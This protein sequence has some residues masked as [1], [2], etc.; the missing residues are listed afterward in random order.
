MRIRI[1]AQTILGGLLLAGAAQAQT[2]TVMGSTALGPIVKKAA[3][4]YMK[5]HPGVQIAVSGGGSMTGL[6]QVTSGGC[7][8]GIS[9]VFATPDQEKSG[10]KNH[11]IVV[12]PFTLIAHPGVGVASLTSQQAEQVFT[13]KINNWKEVGGKDQKIV[14]VIRP[15][16][17]GTR[18]VQ[19]KELLHDQDFSKDVLIQDSTGAVVTAV[20]T[21]PGSVSFV[22]LEH[23]EKNKARV[24]GIA[25]NGVVCTN[26]AVKSGKYP[27]FS[28]GHAYTNPA[29]LGDPKVKQAVE[30]FLAFVLSAEFQ[31]NVLKAG[32]LPVD[33]V[34]SLK[35][36]L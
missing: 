13:G 10:L 32:Y 14:R 3:E 25:Y 16:S 33:Y 11:N 7:H 24:A 18:A 30:G 23:L 9:D 2:V 36:K 28:F 17:S 34:K 27:I 35:A 20:A 31:Q 5:G 4:D 21:T 29:K 8:I 12:Q 22:E 1:L 15:E 26:D 6:N 19:K